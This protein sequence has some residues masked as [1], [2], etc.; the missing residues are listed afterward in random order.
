MSAALDAV[1]RFFVE[2]GWPHERLDDEPATLHTVCRGE[3]RAWNVYV[4]DRED[5]GVL[6]LY[7][8]CPFAPDPD[9]RSAVAEVLT[10]ANYG[11][12]LGAFE[13]DFDDGEI[14]YRTGMVVDGAEL[15]S[16]Y[17]GSILYENVGAMSRYLEP[18]EA[19]ALREVDP[20]IAM[21]AIDE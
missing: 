17:V 11:L 21:D 4:Q 1:A 5:D 13:M 3:G 15:T 2:D 6:L 9:R 8:V 18:I 14:R 12:T 7:S 10:R 20:V 19:V 16:A